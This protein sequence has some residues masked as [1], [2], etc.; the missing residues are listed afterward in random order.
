M[1]TVIATALAAA[2][3]VSLAGP[4]SASDALRFILMDRAATAEPTAPT[5]EPA[6]ENPLAG[7]FGA[8]F[9]EAVSALARDRGDLSGGAFGHTV[10]EAA[11]SRNGRGSRD[12]ADES[13]AAETADAGDD[14]SAGDNGNGGG[15]NGNG[16]G[17]GNGNGR[18]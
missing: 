5:S 2:F 18:S 3:A 4:A 17:G 14:G 9:G 7:L 15:G 8:E 16:N 6:A 13:G 11:S 12:G 10:S 1:K